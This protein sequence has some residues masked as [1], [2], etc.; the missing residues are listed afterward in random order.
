MAW[1]REEEIIDAVENQT[2]INISI[3]YLARVEA[4]HPAPHKQPFVCSLHIELS[5]I[6]LLI[7]WLH[8]LRILFYTR[9]T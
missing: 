4:T 9:I 8:D 3:R 5:S 2:Q 6:T 7:P 1:D